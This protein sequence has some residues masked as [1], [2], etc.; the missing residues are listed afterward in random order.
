[1]KAQLARGNEGFFDAVSLDGRPTVA[2]FNKSERLRLGVRDRGAARCLR[3]QPAALGPE[4]AVGALA[5]LAFALLG[6]VWVARGIERPVSRCRRRRAGSSAARWSKPRRRP[7]ARVRRGRAALAQASEKIARS[8]VELEERVAAAVRQ[9]KDALQQL[10]QSQR[11]EA[12]GQLTGGVAHD[13]NNLLAV[14][15]NNAFVLQR[16]PARPGHVAGRSRRSR[17]RSRSAAA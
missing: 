9:T 10:S 4:V 3:Q 12:L 17:A 7:A 16:R 13:F 2:V 5:L 14:I 8:R 1:M 11:L 6:A 15:G